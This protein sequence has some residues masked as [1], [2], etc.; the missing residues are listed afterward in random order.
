MPQCGPFDLATDKSATLLSVYVYVAITMSLTVCMSVC[1]YELVEVHMLQQLISLCCVRVHGKKSCCLMAAT[2]RG[3]ILCCVR[4]ML[5][6][7]CCCYDYAQ[8]FVLN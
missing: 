3:T 1:K 7:S 6:C 2:Q 5:C 8:I 4:M